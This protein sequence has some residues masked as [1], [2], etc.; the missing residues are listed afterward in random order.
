MKAEAEKLVGALAV[1]DI[2]DLMIK[3]ERDLVRIGK[4]AVNPL[5]E[6]LATEGK[7]WKKEFGGDFSPGGSNYDTARRILSRIV[8]EE[9]MKENIALV[10]VDTVASNVDLGDGAAIVKDGIQDLVKRINGD[11]YELFS[12]FANIRGT[13]YTDELDEGLKLRKDYS[14]VVLVG[15][16]V[17]NEHYD[18]FL[19]L[20]A[21]ARDKKQAVSVH[22]PLD[23]NYVVV[24]D[25]FDGE[26]FMRAE[27]PTADM[28]AVNKYKSAVREFGA[29][30]YVIEKDGSVV[31]SSPVTKLKLWA[32]A[33]VMLQHLNQE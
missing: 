32:E 33:E 11:S 14:D 23:C 3:Y 5:K 8:E 25:R 17:G 31:E 29:A 1:E 19:A 21:Q 13:T 22:I 10:V 15:G 6:F 7:D 9:K 30:A 26:D 24:N 12:E 27:L 20:L 16:D 18:V 4:E 28:Y 2:S